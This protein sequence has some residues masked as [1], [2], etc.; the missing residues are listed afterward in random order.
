VTVKIAVFLYMMTSSLV[1][2]S[3]HFGGTCY[4]RLQ[5]ALKMEASLSSDALVSFYHITW[6]H[7]P[8]RCGIFAQNKNCGAGDTAVVNERL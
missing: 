5:D 3:Q 6:R 1:D 7:V 8:K 4:L 2:R